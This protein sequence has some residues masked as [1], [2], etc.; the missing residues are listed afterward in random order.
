MT[1]VFPTHGELFPRAG[2]DHP[3]TVMSRR[4]NEMNAHFADIVTTPLRLSGF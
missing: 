3:E 4:L 2:E 1:T